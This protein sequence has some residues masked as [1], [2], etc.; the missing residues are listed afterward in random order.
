MDCKTKKGLKFLID[1][2]IITMICSFIL[3]ITNFFIQNPNVTIILSFILIIAFIGL[4]LLLIGAILFLMGRKE[5]GEKHQNNVMKAVI[6]FCI[7]IVVSTVII[8]F[9]TYSTISG[10]ISNL[11]YII[12]VVSI[13]SAVLGTLV[14]YFG[15]IELEDEKGKKILFAAIFV[16]IAI[17]IITSFYTAGLL[18]E[19][20]GSISTDASNYSPSA[21]AL[22]QNVGKIGILSVITSLLFIYALYI[23]Y[24][25]I[26]EGE[27]VPEI[28]SNGYQSIPKRMCPNC[29]RPIPMDSR[30]CPYCGKEFEKHL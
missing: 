16:S 30:V 4:I 1:G 8:S 7:N 28:T 14:Y 9:A 20:F 24:K 10:M 21:L 15:L 13:I 22:T 3:S 23:P 26:K 6:I 17:S 2:M 5:F 12:A 25:R 18:G 19:V 27:L 11:S 29:G